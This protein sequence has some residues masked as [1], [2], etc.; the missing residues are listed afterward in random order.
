MRWKT[1]Q[2][3][4]TAELIDFLK[5]QEWCCV[6][7]SAKLRRNGDVSLPSGSERVYL[8]RRDGDGAIQCALLAADNGLVFP[9][10]SSHSTN[11]FSLPKVYPPGR[12]YSIMG[13][14]AYVRAVES[15]IPRSPTYRVDYYM[16]VL[17]GPLSPLDRDRG[18]AVNVRTASID[19]LDLL[20]PL[21]KRYEREEVLLP[22]HRL[23]TS[24]CY[25]NLRELL[26][27][28][29]VVLGEYRGRVVAKANTNGL[30]FRYDQIGGVFTERRYRNRGIAARLMI[31]LTAVIR[32]R[33]KRVCLFVKR[34]NPPALALYRR[35]GFSVRDDFTISYYT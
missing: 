26:A 17:D 21:Q 30:G 31:R 12:V 23:N 8:A 9:V 34:D 29:T 22:N 2:R 3:A 4:E 20:F 33:G 24:L 27:T 13:R 32:A 11:G 19:D 16:M 14:D 1:A 10:F 6:S 5:R 15:V 28:Q 18:V 7:F 25:R 35:L